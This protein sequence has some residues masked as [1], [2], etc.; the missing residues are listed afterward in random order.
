MSYH[1]RW[2]MSSQHQ[3]RRVG[4]GFRVSSVSCTVNSQDASDIS[5]ADTSGSEAEEREER[6]VFSGPQKGVLFEV[7]K[8]D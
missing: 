8:F 5:T 4:S 1:L 7:I 6:V 3:R 2:F